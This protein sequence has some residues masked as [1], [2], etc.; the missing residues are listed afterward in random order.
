MNKSVRSFAEFKKY[1]THI[2]KKS[3]QVIRLR[4]KVSTHGSMSRKDRSSNTSS[5]AD[6]SI[7]RLMENCSREL[8]S[9]YRGL[10]D[11]ERKAVKKA[12]TEKRSRYCT[13]VQCLKPII[14][15]EFGMLSEIS[16]IEDVMQK[17]MNITST[18]EMLPALDE[19]V[20]GF[21][22]QG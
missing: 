16:Q 4:K 21:I 3:E 7:Q 1:R 20:S 13:F 10:Y 6:P 14:S 2:K 12:M 22:K 15:E 17:L 5:I 8:N 11:R 19:Q 9:H 18:P